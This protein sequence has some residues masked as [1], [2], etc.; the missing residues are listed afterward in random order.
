MVTWSTEY[1]NQH[2]L[3]SSPD[4]AGVYPM[5]NV[6]NIPFLNFCLHNWFKW[7]CDQFLKILFEVNFYT[8]SAHHGCMWICV[9]YRVLLVAILSNLHLEKSNSTHIPNHS[10]NIWKG[11][12]GY[13][14]PSSD[15]S[16][17]PKIL[18]DW[19]EEEKQMIFCCH[20]KRSGKGILWKPVNYQISRL[21]LIIF[22]GNGWIIKHQGYH[23]GNH[24]LGLSQSMECIIVW[25]CEC[26]IGEPSH[27]SYYCRSGWYI[28]W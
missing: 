5:A 23:M 1:F 11:R 22:C 12:K 8:I 18:N 10:Q 17:I 9:W 3:Q 13:V 4:W 2:L 6:L 16:R 26:R 20:L 24:C 15:Q 27:S 7:S 28:N 25:M 19:R 14:G 21:S